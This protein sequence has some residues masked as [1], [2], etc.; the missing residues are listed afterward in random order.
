MGPRMS[1][2]CSANVTTVASSSCWI[3]FTRMMH[4]ALYGILRPGHADRSHHEWP[5]KHRRERRVEICWPAVRGPGVLAREAH[6]TSGHQAG[7]ILGK[8]NPKTGHVLW[9]LADFGLAKLLDWRCI[10]QY[11]TPL[12]LAPLPTWLPRS[13]AMPALPWRSAMARPQTSGAWGPSSPSTATRST[14][15]IRGTSRGG[16]KAN[17][18]TLDGSRYTV[19]FCNMVADMLE[20]RGRSQADGQEDL[21]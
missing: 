10:E 17:Y 13:C 14:C 8:K 3:T 12:A 11:Y 16:G 1:I 19:Q 15:S 6:H 18:S 2:D 4:C 9:K 5:C 20:S 7:H 21:H